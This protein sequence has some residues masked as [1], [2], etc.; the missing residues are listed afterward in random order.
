L[1]RAVDFTYMIDHAIDREELEDIRL[2]I[3]ETSDLSFNEKK[4]LSSYL[5]ERYKKAPELRASA[6]NLPAL[7]PSC[8]SNE[9]QCSNG[10]CECEECR[11]LKA[12][13]LSHKITE[14]EVEKL[15]E[16]I[17]GDFERKNSP[18]RIG[19]LKIAFDDEKPTALFNLIPV[20]QV[21]AEEWEKANRAA[22]EHINRFLS[23]KG[24]HIEGE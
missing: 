1:K 12:A 9:H 10:D 24:I 6:E 11:I 3:L 14:A 22:E 7:C 8:A 17:N 18:A 13:D 2:M 15:K 5:D 20:R 21:D 23:K 19:Q 4:E 16:L